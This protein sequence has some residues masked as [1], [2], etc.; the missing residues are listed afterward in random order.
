M[1]LQ[2]DPV[3]AAYRQAVDLLAKNGI[4][5]ERKKPAEFT[6]TGFF[7]IWLPGPGSNQGPI[8]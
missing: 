4:D 3:T 8:D 2:G 5:L 1:P 6:Q 7:D